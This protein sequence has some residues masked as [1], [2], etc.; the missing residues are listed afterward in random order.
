M[1]SSAHSAQTLFTHVWLTPESPLE[2][3]CAPW[4]QLPHWKMEITE[5][6]TSHKGHK[7]QMTSCLRMHFMGDEVRHSQI[8]I[9]SLMQVRH[10]HSPSENNSR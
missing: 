1:M 2:G 5:L 10:L 4:T 9:A 6:P 8:L 3:H 7:H